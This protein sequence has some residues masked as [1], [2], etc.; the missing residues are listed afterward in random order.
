MDEHSQS[1]SAPVRA[2]Q[3]PTPD[4]PFWRQLRWNLIMYFVALA[5]LPMVIVVAIMLPLIRQQATVQ[6]TNQLVSVA[7]LKISQIT[8]WLSDSHSIL[9]VF[10]SESNREE[11]ISSLAQTPSQA[12]DLTGMEPEQKALNEQLGRAIVAQTFFE[13]FFIY[14]AKGKI[15][16][17]SEPG[18]VGQLVA[19]QPFFNPSMQTEEHYTQPPFYEL[20]R[21]ELTMYATH[22]MHDAQSGQ[23]VAVMAGRLDM[24][25]LSQTMTQWEGLAQSGETYL[26][27]PENNYMITPSRF[28]SDGYTQTRSYHSEGIDQALAGQD[29]DGVYGDYRNPPVPVIGVYRWLPEL[30]IALVAE[31]DEAEALIPYYNARNLSLIIAIAAA[32]VAVL[33]GLFNATRIARPVTVLTQSARQIAA[34]NLKLNLPP[35]RQDE[36]GLL[37]RAF[38]LMAG[39]LD[40]LLTS[41]EQRVADRTHALET[42]AV[43]S[44]SLSTILDEKQLVAAVVEQ[45]RSAFNYYYAHIY[46]FDTTGETLLMAGGTGEAGRTMLM[47]GHS[48]PKGKG[49]VGRAAAT[50]NPVLIPDVSQDS[51][52]L[53]NLLLPDTKAEVAVP[54]AVGERVLGVLDVQHNVAGSLGQA[55]AQLLQSIADQVA[56]ALQ[57]ARLYQQTRQQAEQEALINTIGKKIQQAATIETVLQTAVRELGQALGS[58]RASIQVSRINSTDQRQ[59]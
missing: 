35:A 59:N 17:A 12:T 57:N 14:D 28:E 4:L 22:T 49:L 21:S 31:I 18:R 47:R 7:E 55:E 2:A 9:H 44:R 30:N 46:L 15:I 5:V 29:G 24:N 13:E 33:I 19:N 58:Q 51:G 39:Q 25:T 11:Q 32:V 45:V 8:R 40:D 10:L 48:I 50:N 52:W 27:S 6:G 54:I 1:I 20:G 3:N 16:A 37:T 42:S 56:I 34:G 26:I 38:G 53:P 41:L 36:I 23:P 43:V